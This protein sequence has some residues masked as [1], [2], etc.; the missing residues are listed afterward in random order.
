MASEIATAVALSDHSAPASHS[1]EVQPLDAPP[2]Q[3]AVLFLYFPFLASVCRT[4]AST[5]DDPFITLRYA[6]NFVHGHGLVFNAGQRVQGFTSPLHLLVATVVYLVPGGHDLFKLKLASLVFG[7]LAIREAGI[8]LYRLDLP[9]WASRAG[10][11]IVST[12]WIL[13]YASSNALETTLEVWLLMWLVRLLILDRT[14]RSPFRLAAIAFAAVLARPDAL[15][16]IIGM[17]IAGLIVERRRPIISRV[18]WAAGAAAAAIVWA[19]F[20]LLY[21]GDALPNTYYAKEVAA[22]RAISRGVD[23][24][25]ASLRPLGGTSPGTAILI[26]QLTLLGAGV[27]AV[28]KRFPQCGYLVAIVV[29]QA[30]FILKSGGDWMQGARFATPAIIPLIILEILGLA[31]F[32]P[33]ASRH[34]RPLFAAGFCGAL[35]IVLV[36]CSLSFPVFPSPVWHLKG[37]SDRSLI[38][39]GGYQ[40]S[41][42]WA[43]LPSLL[44]CLRSGDVAA[45]SEVG[46]FGF[47]RQDLRILDL[48]GLTDSSI[49]KSSPNSMKSPTGVDDPTLLQ[50]RSPVG[51]VLLRS[52]PAVIATFDAPPQTS[53]LGGQFRLDTFS[54]NLDISIYV[55]SSP[56]TRCPT[57][58]GS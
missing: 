15:L 21:F 16:V 42:L 41:H 33:Y 54:T 31:I 11:L 34:V 27:Y 57:S 25:I 14:T 1:P 36:A 35:V 58:I 37:V 19:G 29:A 38:A 26:L 17:G 5:T 50:E 23:Y 22:G 39:S 47:V 52:K 2:V 6:A 20:G 13:A 18:W 8:L 32:L 9:R 30:V 51:R 49:A 46:Y 12:S 7:V 48:R 24:L 28:V 3:E 45:T 10:S 4:F 44:S 43:S 56:A 40:D 53:A 55:R